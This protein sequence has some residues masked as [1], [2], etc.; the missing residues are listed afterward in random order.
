MDLQAARDHVFIAKTNLEIASQ[1]LGADPL[2]SPGGPPSLPPGKIERVPFFKIGDGAGRPGAQVEVPVFGG[3]VHPVDGFRVAVGCGEGQLQAIGWSLGAFLKDHLGTAY[4]ARFT[5]ARLG[6]PE[7]Y[8][9]LFLAFF[10]INPDAPP[11]A[12]GPEAGRFTA[13]PV[14]IPHGT[15]LLTVTYE[16]KQGAAAQERPLLC[17]DQWF[18]KGRGW[19]AVKEDATYTYPPRGY[20]DV[21]CVSGTFTIL[22]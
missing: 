5:R 18:Y 21:R 4:E 12:T 22:E 3:C 7:P 17:A 2:P 1:A 13:P 16:V 10:Q 19:D 6:R 15:E 20:T 11:D 8:W 9:A 14:A